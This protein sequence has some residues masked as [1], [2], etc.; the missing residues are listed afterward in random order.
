MPH[1]DGHT[2]TIKIREMGTKIRQPYIIA[3]TANA[4]ETDKKL[5]KESGN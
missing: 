4:F 2:A 3:I 1:M 5:A